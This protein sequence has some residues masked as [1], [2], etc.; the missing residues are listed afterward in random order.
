[1]VRD[2]QDGIIEIVSEYYEIAEGEWHNSTTNTVN[3]GI[4][5]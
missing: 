4:R 1:M 5:Y 3:D 2:E